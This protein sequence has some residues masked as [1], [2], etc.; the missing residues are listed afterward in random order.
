MELALVESFTI[1]AFEIPAQPRPLAVID[2]VF[3]TWTDATMQ[4]KC[5]GQRQRLPVGMAQDL[6][7][8]LHLTLEHLRSVGLPTPLA[9]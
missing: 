5:D 1:Q 2:I 6:A 7:Q 4:T 3:T 8:S 9:N